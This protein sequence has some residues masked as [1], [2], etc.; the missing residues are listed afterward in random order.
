M[1]YSTMTQ[2]EVTR[3]LGQKAGKQKARRPFFFSG[4]RL[5]F[6]RPFSF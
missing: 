6:I 4:S 2:V 3:D 1:W 5:F